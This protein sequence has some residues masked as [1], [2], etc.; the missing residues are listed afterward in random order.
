MCDLVR[1]RATDN[2]EVVYAKV[3]SEELTELLEEKLRESVDTFI[4]TKK[5][6]D[7]AEILEVL[8]GIMGSRGLTLYDLE[9]IRIKQYIKDG[10]FE[11]GIKVVS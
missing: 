9:K 8:N 4:N 10:G 1:D 3:T 5:I 11:K 2:T 6:E 7:M